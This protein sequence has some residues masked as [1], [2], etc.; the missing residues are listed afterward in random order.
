MIKKWMWKYWGQDYA[1]TSDFESDYY[2]YKSIFAVQYFVAYRILFYIISTCI[3]SFATLIFIYRTDNLKPL[4]W[5]SAILI[6]SAIAILINKLPKKKLNNFLVRKYQANSDKLINFFFK[7]FTLYTNKV[8]PIKIWR[9]IKSHSKELYNDLTSENCNGICYYY[10]WIL[11]LIL[12]DVDLIWGGIYCPT[13]HCWYA[14]AFIVKNAY[15]YDSN[16][17]QSY[18][19]DDYAKAQNLKIYKKWSY[20]QYKIKDFHSTVREGFYKWCE[21]NNI[22]SYDCF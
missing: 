7:F 11:G 9:Q 17:R 19:F 3:I 22:T 4:S 18:K 1:N 10:S 12:K 13:T 14:H 20:D 8:I 6:G 15:V 2:L 5:I 21:E 16:F